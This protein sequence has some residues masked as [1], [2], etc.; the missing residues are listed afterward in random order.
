MIGS[1]ILCKK[2][3][4][5][6]P[7]EGLIASLKCFVLPFVDEGEVYAPHWPSNMFAQGYEVGRLVSVTSR[8]STCIF[9]LW[10]EQLTWFVNSLFKRFDALW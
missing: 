10:L 9:E 4:Q 3:D 7:I 2:Y 5:H 6:T 8:T 1:E